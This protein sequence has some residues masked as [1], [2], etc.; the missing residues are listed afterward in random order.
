[1]NLARGIVHLV[2]AGPGDPGLI[3]VSGMSALRQ[4]DVVIF[5]RLVDKALLAESPPGAEHIDV[6]KRPGDAPVSQKEIDELIVNRAKGGLRVVRL[7]GGDPFV[8]GRGYEELSACRE[9]NIDCVVIPGISSAIAAPE[10]AGIPL[11]LRGVSR[12]FAV[13]TAET[14]P[15]TA[16]AVDF[17]QVRGV[18]TLVILMGRSKLE[19]IARTLIQTG[20]RPDMPVACI[21][22]ATTPGQRNISGT[23]ATIAAIAEQMELCAPMVTVIGEVARH[24]ENRSSRLKIQDSK[25]CPILDLQGKHPLFGRKI[26]VTRP[27]PAAMKLATRFVRI[28]AVPIVCPLIRIA[29][30]RENTNLDTTVTNVSAYKWLIFT[31]AHGVKAFWRRLIACGSDA[32]HL[33]SSKLAAVGFATARQLSRRGLN[34]DVTARSAEE[35]ATAIIAH[36]NGLTGRVL[37][38]RGDLA[39][40]ILRDRLSSAGFTVAEPVAYHTHPMSP[41][42][43]V[44]RDLRRGVDAVLLYSPSAAK[45]LASLELPLRDAIIL[46]VG[47]TTAEAAK[48]GG[49]HV[50]AIAAEPSDNGVLA[51]LERCFA[52]KVT[53]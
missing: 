15:E 52:N 13:L 18:D 1:M 21:E 19:S 40:P 7:K 14:S 5:D 48:A 29:I 10:V 32:R 36:S 24:A 47:S 31:S 20:W 9:N 6:G 49:L 42:P 53:A 43:A 38:P 22:Q 51:Q 2:G 34:A 16:N 28:G 41:A 23:L 50:D 39:M 27:R 17:A 33:S 3:T 25:D 12:S 46:C 26:L 11:T 44:L 8:F 35:L 37:W 30:P 4:A 45:Q